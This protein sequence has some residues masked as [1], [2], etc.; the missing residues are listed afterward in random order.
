MPVMIQEKDIDS[1]IRCQERRNVLDLYEIQNTAPNYLR[2]LDDPA[3][4]QGIY[5]PFLPHTRHFP[6]KSV[7]FLDN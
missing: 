3:F 2:I 6:I 5:L 1:W 4:R 7:K